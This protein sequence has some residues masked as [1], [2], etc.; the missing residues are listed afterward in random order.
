[1]FMQSGDKGFFKRAVAFVVVGM[2]IGAPVF[3]DAPPDTTIPRVLN[4]PLSSDLVN[5]P[6]DLRAVPVPEPTNLGEFVKNRT[7]AIALGKALF[8]DM[9]VGS[10]GT[11]ACASCHFRAGADPRTKNQLSPGLKHMPVADLNY[12]NGTGPNFQIQASHFPLTRLLNPGVRGALDPTTDNNDVISSQ[13]I[14]HLG[15]ELDPLGFSIGTVNVRRVEPRNTPS[16]INAVFNHRQFWDG[17]AENIFN[18]VNHLGKRDPNA[19]IFRADNQNTLVEVHIE[20]PNSSLASQAVAPI[21]SDLEMADPD[22][23]AQDVGRALAKE[24]RDLGKKTNK[25]RPLANQLVSLTDSVLGSMS[26]WPSKGLSFSRYDN[27]IK[28]VFYEKWWKSKKVIRVNDDG[29]KTIVSKNNGECED[30]NCSEN[31]YSLI[32]YNFSLLRNCCSAL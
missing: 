26:R 21:V 16:M 10:D 4:P 30:N 7:M 3:A 15:G 8:W 12:L 32:Q 28:E 17:R 19:K 9:Q 29:S 22:R 24:K 2:L 31:E 1:M 25:V 11:Q 13:G 14:H 18:G 5:L 23:T 6:G 20:L 27:M